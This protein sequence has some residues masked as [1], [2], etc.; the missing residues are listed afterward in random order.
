MAKKRSKKGKGRGRIAL[1]VVLFGLALAVVAFFTLMQLV[2]SG[3]FGELPGEA[4]LG[5]I[6][7]E[8]ATL[9]LAADGTLIGKIFAQDRTNIRYE[10][11]PQHLIDALVSTE[12]ARFFE[13]AGVDGR[14]YVR[15]FFRT[16]LG[17]DRS[18][19]GG[20]T[21]SQQIVK[22]LYGR[23]KHG[24]LTIPVNKMKEALVAQRL[25][26]VLSKNDVLVLYFNSVPFGENTYGIG[27]A[28]QR[29]FGKPTKRL[30][31]E[32]GAVLVGMLKANTSYNPRLHP[33]RSKDRRD[34]V[35]EL[36]HDRGHLDRAVTD[37]LRKRVID[38]N[39][40][41]GDVL[42]L[43]G[44]F[45]QHVADEARLILKDITK[46]TGKQY[47]LEKDGLRITTT[48]DPA[49]QQ[50]AYDA[51]HAHL[52][53]MQPKLDRELRSGKVRAGWEKKTTHRKER[54]WKSN[55]I[56]TGE[57]YDHDGKRVDT[58]SYRD[59]LWHYHRMLNASVLMMDP[60]SGAVRAWIGGNDHRYLPYDLVNAKRPVASTIKP[61]VYAAAIEGGMSPCDYLDNSRQTYA[62]YDDWTPDN[63]DRDTI[64]GSVAMWYALTRSMNR[65]TVDLY[66][67]TGTDTLRKVMTDLG[68]PTTDVSNPAMALGATDIALHDLVPAYGAFANGG[69]RVVPQFIT[70]ISDAQGKVLYKAKKVK[71]TR[72]IKE[73][74]AADITAMLQRAVNEGTGASLR[75]RYGVTGPYA[76]KT[77]TSQGYSDA[78][79]VAYTS[80]LVIGTW[81]GAFDP[82]I[83]FTSANG[84]GGQLAL[85]IV[86]RVLKGIEAEPALR[87]KYVTGFAWMEAE[88]VA[89]NCEPRL[90]T[91]AVDRFVQKLFRPSRADT[92][93]KEDRPSFFQRLFQKKE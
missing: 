23:G 72:A 71:T 49:L 15:V 51:A 88:D 56:Y 91:S 64:E 19:G 59:S 2:S 39:Y 30:R 7:H 80:N 87:K 6:R 83:H 41:G 57:L 69:Q 25:E 75:S 26:R 35:L 44:Y 46:A 33:E 79:F 90:T 48:I 28:A 12:D 81:V 16:L 62:A 8:Q 60:T 86:G 40:T 76:G 54:R 31:V 47:D 73:Q 32:E 20:S 74:T 66:F 17:R 11:L 21:I 10:D 37:S 58:L 52:A 38:L 68:L 89:M 55:P 36:M 93:A 67:H 27:S 65:P 70:S 3:V 24:L 42:D 13:H 29:F 77:G 45:N 92:A 84:T 61:I 53:A 5:N 85:P 82:D 63:F 34:Q 9:V 1:K 18:G 22:N 4:E 50:L 43:Y 14:S 78:W